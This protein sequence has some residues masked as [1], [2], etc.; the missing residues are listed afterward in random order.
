MQYNFDF[1]GSVYISSGLSHIS[2]GL[3]ASAYIAMPWMHAY[4]VYAHA[5]MNKHMYVCIRIYTQHRMHAY[6]HSMY[7]YM[8]VFM[9]CMK[10]SFYCGSLVYV[11]F[12]E[13]MEMCSHHNY[14]RNRQR[15]TTSSRESTVSNIHGGF[16]LMTDIPIFATVFAPPSWRTPLRGKLLA[17][18]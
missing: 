6:V 12:Q 7:V 4:Y 3:S 18:T 15:K 2:S 9:R 5:C 8:N 11:R 10:S 1:I 14:K 17:R 16:E 13:L